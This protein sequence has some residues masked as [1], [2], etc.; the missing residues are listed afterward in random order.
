[1]PE[2]EALSGRREVRKSE[3]VH[4]P[5][6]D[7]PNKSF[8]LSEGRIAESSIACRFTQNWRSAC[9]KACSDIRGS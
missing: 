9:S 8:T 4:L 7:F 5:L 1:M 3:R 2:A 6:V